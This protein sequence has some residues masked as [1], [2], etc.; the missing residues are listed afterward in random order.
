MILYQLQKKWRLIS[1]I[2]AKTPDK[3]LKLAARAFIKFQKRQ[4]SKNQIPERL[5]LFVTNRCN[6]RCQ[7]CFY[8]PH[9]APAPEM[10]LDQMQKIASSANSRI[11]QVILTGG[12]CFLRN[13]LFD[14][15]ISFVNNGCQTINI[16]TNG[17]MPEKVH[18]FLDQ[19]LEKTKVELVFMV[20]F[21]GPP[22]VH[23]NIRGVQGAAQKTLE[24]IKLL[25]EYYK[26]YPRRFGNV[27]V[28]TTINHL[29]LAFL[30]ETVAA[31]QP[32]KNIGHSFGFT[33]SAD[34][35][36]FG[37]PAN[38]LSGFDVDKKI[39]LNIDE[40]K[41]VLECLDREVWDKNVSL[42]SLSNRQVMAETIRIL[43]KKATN[44]ICL[45]GK[46]EM[47]IYPEG[48]V[49]ICEMLKPI[50]SLKETDYDLAKFHKRHRE[51][52]Q[53]PRNC[54]CTHDCAIL[55]SIRFSSDSIVEMIKRKKYN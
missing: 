44:F 7:H 2:V 10:S 46:T 32:F 38:S 8:I 35:N 12:E 54:R 49:G 15:V 19:A 47:I 30:P 23:D 4:L 17:T 1:P 22:A 53:A 34:L 42:F 6:L 43:E 20:S 36:T 28:S 3:I 55:S 51:K 21:D 11:K 9:V 26:K 33:R 52:F 41:K 24:T 27:F 45:A 13:D 39:I 16:I 5:V 37:A 18:Q 31:I 29:N 40:M 48:N 25:S 50:G 14:I